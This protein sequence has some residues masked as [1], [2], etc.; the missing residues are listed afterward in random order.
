M[1]GFKMKENLFYKIKTTLKYL[2]SKE[3]SESRALSDRNLRIVSSLIFSAASLVLTI[4]NIIDFKQSKLVMTI[5]TSVLVVGFLIVVLLSYLLN[6]KSQIPIVLM[7]IL[8]G[9]IFSLFIIY[10]GNDGFAAL[11]VLIVPPIAM[12]VIGFIPGSFLSIYYQL[13]LIVIFY[14]PLKGII[15]GHEAIG[16]Y[17]NFMLRFPLLYATIFAA[18]FVFTAQKEYYFYLNEKMAYTDMLT[19]LKNRSFFEDCRKEIEKEG[20]L[21]TL[22]IISVDLNRLKYY[23]DY[24]GHE[25]GD[26]RLI[27]TAKIL[28]KTFNGA[29]AICRIGGDEFIVLTH[30]PFDKVDE[31]VINLRK[32]AETYQDGITNELT[33][34]IGLGRYDEAEA[35]TFHLISNVADKEMYEDKKNF[36]ERNHIDRRR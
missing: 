34:S 3:G 2:A 28:V 27:A 17:D 26:Q 35:N 15:P 21:K 33:I 30:L 7:C 5:S 10:G 31:Q 18:S 16:Y 23:N 8:V 36:Y 19:D 25:A 29:D 22:S 9:I 32:M 20:S 11:W 24:Y 13:F 14:T 4:L 12:N 6:R 1:H